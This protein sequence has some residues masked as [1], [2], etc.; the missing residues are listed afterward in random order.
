MWDGVVEQGS[1]MNLNPAGSTLWL[2]IHIS[3][4]KFRTTSGSRQKSL[5][6]DV[7]D[8]TKNNSS[9]QKKKFTLSYTILMFPLLCGNKY[10]AGRNSQAGFTT[11]NNGVGLIKTYKPWAATSG[12]QWS[13]CAGSTAQSV[14]RVSSLNPLSLHQTEVMWAPCLSHMLSSVCLS[15]RHSL[16]HRV[17]KL[18][19]VG[20]STYPSPSCCRF[21]HLVSHHWENLTM[22]LLN[23]SC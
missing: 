1:S 8:T 2:L 23:A 11:A 14:V 12:Q 6:P 18:L 15:P 22:K 7:T 5:F 16:G 17:E 13:A 21:F 9:P 10:Q 20:F 3:V 4:Q 19:L